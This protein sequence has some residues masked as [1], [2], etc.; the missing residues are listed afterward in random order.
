MCFD[1]NKNTRSIAVLAVVCF[2]FADYAYTTGFFGGGVINLHWFSRQLLR[3]DMV[4]KLAWY[5]ASC[6]STYD[7][8]SANP[9]G[10][11][12]WHLV[13]GELWL[14]GQEVRDRISGQFWYLYGLCCPSNFLVSPYVSAHCL[15][16]AL[17]AISLRG[18]CLSLFP[19]M[20]FTTLAALPFSMCF[21]S[22]RSHSSLG[23]TSFL[24][25]ISSSPQRL[26]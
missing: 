7:L 26:K 1:R 23:G 17:V 11:C 8:T 10:L 14:M 19:T 22:Q 15:W 6:R 5:A 16:L 3:W 9:I 20:L 21:H 4:V 13:C 12:K 2:I 24:P 25:R 18:C